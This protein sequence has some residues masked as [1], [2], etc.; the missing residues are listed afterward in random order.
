MVWRYESAK[1]IFRM[2][3]PMRGDGIVR[4]FLRGQLRVVRELKD[5][6]EGKETSQCTSTE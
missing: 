4:A 1:F 5:R 3:W 6:V 2:N